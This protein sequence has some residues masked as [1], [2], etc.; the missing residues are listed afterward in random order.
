MQEV[1]FDL[2]TITPLFLAGADQTTAELRSPSFRGEMRYWLRALVGGLV[3]T[4][5][6]GLTRIKD[7]ETAVFGAT[8]TGSAVQVRVSQ[9]SGKLSQFT[10]NISRPGGKQQATGKGYLLWSMRLKKPPRYYFAPR[11]R[12]QICLSTRGEDSAKYKKGIASLWLLTHL[13]GVGSRS[14]RCAGS[15]TI[16][17]HEGDVYD[18]PFNIP[19]DANSLKSQIEQGIVAA[20]SLYTATQSSLSDA[21]FDALSRNTCRIWILQQERPWETPEAAME[22]IGESLQS[23]RSTVPIIQRKVFG[24]PLKGVRGKVERRA[25]PLLLRLVELQG[26]KYVGLAVLF[27]TRKSDVSMG[28]YEI[29]ETWTNEFRGK[30]EVQL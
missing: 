29:I 28:D 19:A 9:P 3:G 27:K 12:F 7:A 10:E 11:T 14:R 18:F 17:L 21:R 26:Q 1:T 15:L 23:Y 24:F 25:S 20:R 30:K 2:Q 4:N 5:D 13:G 16:T 8:D 22:A 6:E